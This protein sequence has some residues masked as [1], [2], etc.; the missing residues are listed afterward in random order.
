MHQTNSYTPAR[1]V[2][3]RVNELGFTPLSG[4]LHARAAE[5]ARTLWEVDQRRRSIKAPLCDALFAASASQPLELRQAL[6]IPLKRAIF[7]ERSTA[8][9]RGPAL[10]ACP[11]PLLGEWFALEDRH[12]ALQA[13]IDRAHDEVIARERETLAQWCAH[14]TFQQALAVSSPSVYRAAR[15]YAETP[16]SDHPARLRKSEFG[17]L[18]YV[19]RA[20]TRTTP[21]SLYTT[22]GMA[23][24]SPQTSAAYPLPLPPERASAAAVDHALVRRFL[25]AVVRH[26]AVIPHLRYA[27]TADLRER[28][29]TFR[30]DVYS[31]DAKAQPRVFRTTQRLGSVRATP[32]LRRLVAWMQAV[33][34]DDRTYAAIGARLQAWVPGDNGTHLQQFVDRLID[35][36][37]I[38]PCIPVPEQ[39]LDILRHAAAFVGTLPCEPALRAEPILSE[40]QAWLDRFPSATAGERI[41]ALTS[42]AELWTR[43]FEAVGATPP[44]TPPVYEDVALPRQIDFDTRAWQAP[45]DDLSRLLAA[46]EVFDL[47]M[48]LK[49]VIR[50]E[51]VAAYGYGG[52][53]DNLA[54]IADLVPRMFARL[55][56]LLLRD[57]QDPLERED[58]TLTRLDA[59]KRRFLDAIATDTE[60]VELDPAF[61]DAIAAE[62]PQGQLAD[63]AS[64][65]AFVQPVEHNGEIGRLV[66]NHVYNGLGMFASRFL[67]LLEPA[68]TTNLRAHIAASFPREHLVAELRTVCGFNGNLHPPLA[69]CAIDGQP[70]DGATAI[71]AGDLR[72]EHDID[73][74]AVIVRSQST[75]RRVNVLYLGLLVPYLLPQRTRLLYSLEGSG[76]LNVPFHALA[77]VALSAEARTII[78]R[79]PRVTFGRVVLFRRRWYMPRAL[80]PAPTANESDSAYFARFNAWRLTERLPAEFFFREHARISTMESAGDAE[81]WRQKV[82]WSR[83]KPQYISADSPLLIRHLAKWLRN[84]TSENDLY[85]EEVLPEFSDSVFASESGRH[86]T[87][88]VVELNRAIRPAAATAG[89]APE[90]VEELA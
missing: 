34:E 50:D 80:V 71:P 90:I 70:S 61:I 63:W 33:D 84:A 17:L 22:V 79:Y 21:F 14:P 47:K 4:A 86:V 45:L 30:Y 9:W 54:A 11:M 13:E 31:D 2:V 55:F 10:A 78:R 18:Q 15:T 44:E 3:V 62:R 65:G 81:G 64:Y 26:P 87:E 40:M 51:F 29:G 66:V 5:V 49:R 41:G 67:Y 89:R 1:H 39:A 58:V 46:L 35:A 20:L 82:S 8:A 23:Q 6:L 59:L 75:G 24:L 32:L 28:D 69:S 72:F 88:V 83:S 42:L 74:D 12:Q 56:R 19:M 36:E 53:C 16:L 38:V 68:A 57:G 85:F 48:P 27:V 77:E 25:H 73:S 37:L 43:A 7:N 52:S 60:T 76:Q